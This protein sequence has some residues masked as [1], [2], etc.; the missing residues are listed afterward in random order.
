MD[1]LR[2]VDQPKFKKVEGWTKPSAGLGFRMV[3]NI[4][5]DSQGRIY[6]VHRGPKPLR[7]FD[8]DGNYLGSVAD[9]HLT[10]SV[11]YDLD[12]DPPRPIGKDLGHPVNG[13]VGTWLAPSG[14]QICSPFACPYSRLQ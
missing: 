1:T 11:N 9:S 4:A 10:Q 6:V 14:S 8:L 3:S 7:R 13:E 2:P 5:A 12:A